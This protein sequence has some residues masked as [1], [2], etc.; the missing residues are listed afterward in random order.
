DGS[1]V[2]YGSLVGA[3]IERF[4]PV[5][6]TAAQARVELL[7]FEPAASD[8]PDLADARAVVAGGR[9]LRERFFPLLRP[10][11]AELDAAIG[12]TRAA[13][14]GGWAPGD[15]QVGQTGKIIAP[16]LYVAVGISGSIQHVAGIR[17]ARVIVAIDRDP[18][19]PI[20]EVADYGL[21]ADFGVAVP[22][23]TQALAARREASRA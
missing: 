2:E 12:A 17:A 1:W 15:L 22:A 9:M 5:G 4:S 16:E 14:D 7:A 21:V 3:P 19:A 20:F 23:L 11:A 18:E 8:R 6:P 10:L 13:C